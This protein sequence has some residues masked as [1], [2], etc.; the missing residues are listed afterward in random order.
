MMVSALDVER[1][2]LR[3]SCRPIFIVRPGPPL[4]MPLYPESP[5]LPMS[6][7]ATHDRFLPR[8]AARLRWRIEGSGPTLVLLH[9]WALDLDYWEPAVPLLARH[10]ALLRFD[11]RGFGL[12]EG[13]PDPSR[14][15]A[16]L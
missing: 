9:G 13:R 7:Q 4:K 2:E 10:F 3:C 11:R 14:D 8:D 15:V 16:D 5:Q 1:A 12:S 6:T